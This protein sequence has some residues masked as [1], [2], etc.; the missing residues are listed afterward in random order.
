MNK[1]KKSSSIIIYWVWSEISLVS[2]I[3]LMFMIS[4]KNI[5]KNLNPNFLTISVCSYL[6]IYLYIC[7][8][9][10]LSINLSVF[11]YVSKSVPIYLSGCPPAAHWCSPDLLTAQPYIRNWDYLL[12]VPMY[13]WFHNTVFLVQPTWSAYIHI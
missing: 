8:S 2:N 12:W 13:I 4:K 6:S 3:N 9:L 10:F 11:P 1:K 7:L 5:V